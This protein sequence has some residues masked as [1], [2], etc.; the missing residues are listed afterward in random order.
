MRKRRLTD[1][2]IELF[3]VGYDRDSECITFPVRDID[4]NCL[5]VARRSVHTKFFSYPQG[6]EKPVYGLYELNN[7][8]EKP[9]EIIIC[10]SMIDALTCWVYGKPAV[11]L[12]GL[13]TETQFR[14]LND[15]PIRKYI[16]AT[17]MDNAGIKARK[18]IKQGL[19]R[20][21]VTEYVWDV[22]KFKDIND[23]EKEDFLNLR[24]IF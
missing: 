21:L 12:N 3:D 15:F 23:M 1:E 17:D 9:K 13:G 14:D 18:R 2:I 10:E 24:E 6:V 22:N 19:K 5:F 16:L 7:S 8:N 20:K 4:G 11:A